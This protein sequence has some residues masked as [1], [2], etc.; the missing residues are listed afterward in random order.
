MPA[1]LKVLAHQALAMFMSP[2]LI[3]AAFR[4][5][6]SFIETHIF[7]M[8]CTVFITHRCTCVSFDTFVFI[9]LQAILMGDSIFC[10]CAERG[11]CS[12]C[13]TC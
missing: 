7:G 10:G 6:A 3:C 11:A 5:I 1:F 9:K 12:G 8:H 4:R 13:E 2:M